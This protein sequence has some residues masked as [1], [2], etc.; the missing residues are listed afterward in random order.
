MKPVYI[1]LER[2][3]DTVRTVMGAWADTYVFPTMKKAEA[4][5]KE[6][7]KITSD[8]WLMQ[9]I[10]IPVPYAFVRNSNI[11]AQLGEEEAIEAS[12]Y[13]PIGGDK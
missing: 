2:Y 7:K 12:I 8:A 13:I 1:I 9:Y 4:Y 10:I 11:D 6:Y 5:L 3:K